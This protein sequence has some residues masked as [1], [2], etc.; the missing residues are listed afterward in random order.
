MEA[1]SAFAPGVCARLSLLPFWTGKDASAAEG[2]HSSHELVF[3][4]REKEND[5]DGFSQ[6]KK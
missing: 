3:K 5:K 4:M 6:R 2:R 1:Q